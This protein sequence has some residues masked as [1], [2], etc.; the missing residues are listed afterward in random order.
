M[1]KT[2]IT[3]K[4]F[5]AAF[6]L[7]FMLEPTAV[8][9]QGVTEEQAP[10][11]EETVEPESFSHQ[12]TFI[13]S[14]YYSPLQGQNRYVT[15]SYAGDIRLNGNGTNG[16]D[17]TQVYPGMIAAPKTYAFGTKMKIPG[18]GV[19][20]VHDRGGAIVNAGQRGQAHDRLDIW[21]G[22][23]DTGLTRA[24]N[25]GRRTVD[26]TVYG[27]ES[28]I[29]EEIYLEGYSE[30]EKYLK[31]VINPKPQL[32]ANDLSYGENGTEVEKLQAALKTLGYY[33]NEVSKVYDVATV[34]AVIKFQVDTQVIDIATDFGAGYF[35]PQTRI[36]LENVIHE[37]EERTKENLPATTLGKDDNGEEVKKLQEA[38]KQ[39]GYEIEV[40][41]IYDSKT[42]DAIFKFQK[43]N[44]IVNSQFDSG[45]GYFGPQTMQLLAAKLVDFKVN[46]VS[47]SFTPTI[48]FEKDLNERDTDKDVRKLQE[49]LRKLNLFGT[50]ASGFYGEVTKNA[51]FKFQQN[52]GLVQSLESQGAG[53]FGV[54]TR[55]RLNE[56]ISQR[57]QTEKLIEEKNVSIIRDI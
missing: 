32:F 48:V 51:V 56:I 44:Q 57:E 14:A 39:L 6:V 36:A 7:I 53:R 34:E 54:L 9:A 23:G 4:F 20:A 46:S 12:K 40:T 35:G 42:I 38:L 29:Q 30:A 52:M 17:G 28:A 3:N 21:M 13:I 55:T 31:K 15:G 45:A 37:F 25:W 1:V 19:V 27:V 5:I 24:L 11:V 8:F 2:K 49:E 33:S 22:H 18:I 16:A 47:E 26:V 41:G 10:K 50:D 43:D